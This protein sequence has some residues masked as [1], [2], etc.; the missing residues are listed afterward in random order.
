MEISDK[1]ILLDSDTKPV[2]HRNRVVMS[3]RILMVLWFL[4]LLW[5]FYNYYLVRASM[6]SP[7]LPEYTV[8][9]LFSGHAIKGSFAVVGMLAAQVFHWAKW[10]VMAIAVLILLFV[11]VKFAYPIFFTG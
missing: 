6:D 8:S 10:H 4:Y 2:S 1:N 5:V 3:Y 7:L 11:A 9:Y